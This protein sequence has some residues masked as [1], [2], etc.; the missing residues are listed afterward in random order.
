MRVRQ[1]F[2]QLRRRHQQR[3]GINVRVSHGRLTL[4][5]PERLA[6]RKTHFLP[7]E[8]ARTASQLHAQPWRM[9]EHPEPDSTR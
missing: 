1:K 8:A 4:R 2:D 7:I 3:S 9:V 6:D 5:V